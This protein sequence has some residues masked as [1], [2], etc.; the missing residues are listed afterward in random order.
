MAVKCSKH[1]AEWRNFIIGTAIRCVLSA[2][3]LFYS[4]IIAMSD[5]AHV[6]PITFFFPQ[7]ICIIVP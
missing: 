4:H 7:D 3:E 1:P 5:E 2:H 6:Y